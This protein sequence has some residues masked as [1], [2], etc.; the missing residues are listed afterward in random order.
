MQKS[1]IKAVV[2]DAYGTVFDVH[3]VADLADAM[4]PGNG[5]KLSQLWRAK[6]LEYMFL[7]TLMGRYVPHNENTEAALV[8]SCNQLSLDATPEQR[9]H[10]MDAYLRLSPFPDAEQTLTQLAGY[11]RA[12]LSVG[13]L[14]MLEATAENAR[15]RS[16]FDRLISVDAVKVYKPHPAVYQLVLDELD[17]AKEEVAFV[18]SN[19]FDVAGAK[20]FGF[21]VYWIN[22]TQMLPDELGLLPDVVLSQLGEIP[23]ALR[24]YALASAA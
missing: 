2:F 24:S 20:A 10:L 22:R 7:R 18:T 9:Q 19:F 3:S 21:R 12:I 16:H 15:L 11:K 5:G 17:V 1:T 23:E 4:F 14:A 13:T 8:Y 6:Q